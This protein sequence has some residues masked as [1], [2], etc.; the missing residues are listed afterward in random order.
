MCPPGAANAHPGPGWRLH[1][2]TRSRNQLS[3]PDAAD[4]FMTDADRSHFV[5]LFPP[6]TFLAVDSFVARLVADTNWTLQ[7]QYT[8]KYN[9]TILNN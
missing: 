7:R 3:R 2:A 6:P 1:S 5:V 8:I 9:D 4:S